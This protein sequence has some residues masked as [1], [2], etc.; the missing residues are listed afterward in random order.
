MKCSSKVEQLNIAFWSVTFVVSHIFFVL[1]KYDGHV[2]VL[3]KLLNI[4]LH[5]HAYSFKTIMTV[6]K[7]LLSAE[8]TVILWINVLYSILFENMLI[9]ESYFCYFSHFLVNLEW[10]KNF[11]CSDSKEYFAV[12]SN[13][14][15]FWIPFIIISLQ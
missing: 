2:V 6:T 1:Q 10:L 13:K 12:Y 5:M 14:S 15:W 11:A 7:I 4:T 8:W 9:L 3:V